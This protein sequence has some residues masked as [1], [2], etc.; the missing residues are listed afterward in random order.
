MDYTPNYD[1]MLGSSSVF[2]GTRYD[3]FLDAFPMHD[4]AL[5]ADD[6]PFQSS[7][8]AQ[9]NGLHSQASTG[10]AVELQ[11]SHDFSF[12]NTFGYS[13]TTHVDRIASSRQPGR[14]PSMAQQWSHATPKTLI[15]SSAAE[16]VS[17]S[18]SSSS[19]QVTGPLDD[20]M[21]DS[22]E[23][24]AESAV[25]SS[26][27]PIRQ[28][29]KITITLEH[30]DPKILESFLNAALQSEAKISFETDDFGT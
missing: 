22:D 25:R 20:D 16:L 30:V 10:G 19:G 27:N 11:S 15:P 26:Q 28:K 29:R 13:Q 2:D 24:G 3:S 5:G 1:Q 17:T 14:A 12:E 21:S 8:A 9:I 4:S 18:K 23:A 7:L 6:Q